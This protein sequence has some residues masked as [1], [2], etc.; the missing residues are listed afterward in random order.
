[1]VR[2]NGSH[3]EWDAVFTTGALQA[4]ERVGLT[5]EEA[6]E[7]E[8]RWLKENVPGFGPKS[9]KTLREYFPAKAPTKTIPG[10]YGG[11]LNAG[12]TPGNAGGF[13][14]PSE[15]RK[16]LLEDFAATAPLLKD[17]AN[18]KMLPPAERI[19]AIKELGN[20]GIGPAKSG[21]TEEELEQL[22]TRLAEET[23]REL[24]AKLRS[25]LNSAEFDELLTDLFDRW[26]AVTGEAE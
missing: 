19:R 2:H 11:R 7:K 22:L 5:V 10:K 4:L 12:G 24:H 9:I 3:N 8:T 18:D 14:R 16:M 6:G 20:F 25:K 23:M 15:V 1:M 13:K 21:Y 26:K 17:F